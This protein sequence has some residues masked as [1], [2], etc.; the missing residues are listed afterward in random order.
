MD[1]RIVYIDGKVFKEHCILIA[2][3][4]DSDGQK[5]VLGL[6]EGATEN[7]RVVK[8]LITDL[9]DRG[10][11]TDDPILFVIDGAKALRK[12]IKDV[13]GSYGVVQRCQVHKRRN[14]IAHLP[15][16]LLASVD[17]AMKD[18]YHADSAELAKQ[19]LNRL[20]GS[21]DRNHPG[22]ANSLREG[23][24]ETLTVIRLG[25]KDALRWTLST[26]NPVENLNGSVE[27]YTRNVKRWRHG[28]MIVRWVVAALV[29]AEKKFRRIRGYRDLADLFAS[30]DQHVGKV[31][32][33]VQAA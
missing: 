19:Q 15:E 9:V 23:L 25:V 30:L 6:R 26:T 28:K 17:R 21:L 22:A 2:L 29:D 32:N 20:A 4:I 8:A 24:D 7:A 14:V 13:F 18:A 31:Q 11:S 3:G 5:H 27:H 10:L 1:L 16:D 12:A 33:E